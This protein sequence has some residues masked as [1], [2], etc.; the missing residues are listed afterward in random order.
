MSPF[1][2]NCPLEEALEAGDCPSA[3]VQGDASHLLYLGHKEEKINR[4]DTLI[5]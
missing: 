4:I 1:P 3:V 2:P 5:K